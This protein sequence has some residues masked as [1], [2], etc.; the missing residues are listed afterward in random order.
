MSTIMKAI[1]LTLLL[2]ASRQTLWSQNED[3]DYFLWKVHMNGSE[4]T[5]SGSIHA[6][7]PEYFPL[8]DA[9]MMAYSQADYVILEVKEDSKTLQDMVFSYAEKD[10]LEEG[11]YLDKHLSPESKETLSVMFKGKEDLLSRYYRYE[12]WLLNSVVS[13]WRSVYFGYNPEWSVDRYFHDLATRD[14]KEI[15]GLD[16]VETQLAL[17]DFDVPFETQLKILESGIR[18][19]EHRAHAEEPLFDNY[20]GYDSEGFKETFLT[21][22]NLENPQMKAMY[23]EVFVS[24]NKAWVREL[25]DLSSCHP[26]TYFMVVGSGHYFGPDNV[27]ELLESKGFTVK[28]Y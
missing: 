19:A 13:V 22:M 17:F 4:V 28:H 12:G 21:L 27:L 16:K 26:G 23:D 24:R 1:M 6:G 15:I 9:Y 5:L 2:L 8:P 7:K 11:Q 20:Y 14:H 25:I 3:P 18:S 10:S